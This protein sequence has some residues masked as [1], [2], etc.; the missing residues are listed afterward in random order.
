MHR[1][2]WLLVSLT[3]AIGIAQAASFLPWN[4][5][6]GAG[7]VWNFPGGIIE[8][9]ANDMADGIVGYY[10]Q[11]QSPW[12]LRFL[13][14]PNLAA[15]GGTN[16]FWLD[17]IPWLCFVAKIV[18]GVTGS[19]WNPQGAY[20]AS[21]LVLPGVA[22]V[23][24]VAQLG[25]RNLIA[26]IAGTLIADSTPFLLHRW[27]H[28][29]LQS[30]FLIILALALYV[31]SRRRPA[32]CPTA[33]M[34]IALLSIALMT[35]VYLF[36]MVGG[37]W[38]A[39]WIDQMRH[40]TGRTFALLEAA[41]AIGTAILLSIPLGV[42]D[43]GVGGA[44]SWGYGVWSMN[45][46]SPFIPQLSGVVP[47]LQEYRLGFP[48]QYEGFAWSGFGAVTLVLAGHRVWFDWMRRR[49][50]AHWPL[51]GI[52][53]FFFLFAA[54][55][56]LTLGSHELFDIPLSDYWRV[57]VF[58]IF[59]SSGRFFWPI[60]YA[61]MA[62]SIVLVLTRMRPNR[63]I[64]LLLIASALQVVDSGPLRSAIHQSAA[65][66]RP[67]S[68]DRSAVGA[69]VAKA[70]AIEIYPSFGCSRS[71][72]PGQPERSVTEAITLEQSN[73]EI[74]MLAARR[75]LP[76]NSVYHARA[77]FDCPAERA[78]QA[79]PLRPGTA[80]FYLE[81]FMPGPDQLLG[82]DPATICAQLR[83]AHYCLPA[84]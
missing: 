84:S 79:L 29:A 49:A 61:A 28:S 53:L 50:M 77:V 13:Y 27:G 34:W 83:G 36:V 39:A 64:C 6:N 24:L 74:Q 73:L 2:L 4:F 26:A 54:S 17:P 52:F 46:A 16:T 1:P 5:V 12:T 56:R 71:R 67:P 23:I 45:L 82:R 70:S 51:I 8:N 75:N 80:Y 31:R 19:L 66:P 78:K 58:G 33:A 32:D 55:N 3:F 76:I 59:R 11:L 65:A 37:V 15:P 25:Q 43:D 7:E 14:A 22:M 72:A 63:A 41:A 38:A 30:Q 48:Q 42:L 44:G 10:Y 40:G 18:H 21:T 47:W 57:H 68:V 20:M 35:N 60:G 81:P 9:G 69:V 62:A